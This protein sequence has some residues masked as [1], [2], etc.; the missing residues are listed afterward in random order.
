MLH[1]DKEQQLFW[2]NVYLNIGLIYYVLPSLGRSVV[3]PGPVLPKEPK[4]MWL[5]KIF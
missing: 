2:N 1:L 5:R 3:D 4:F